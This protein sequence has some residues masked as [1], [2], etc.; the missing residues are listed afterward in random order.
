MFVQVEL[1]Y[2]ATVP[3][4]AA[5]LSDPAYGRSRV[6]AGGATAN[7]IEIIG[8]S[9]G[10]FTV[11]TRRSMPTDQIPANIRAFVGT[12]LEVRQ[13]EA[14]EAPQGDARRGTVVVEIAG[15]PVRLTGTTSLVHDGVHGA[16]LTYAGEVKAGVPLFGAAI[17]DAAARAV[18]SALEAEQQSGNDWLARHPEGETV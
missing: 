12:S 15:A 14:W 5:M 11:T 2:R 3:T 13:I 18:R 9:D 10:A 1:R 16:V 4:V 8:D 6:A 7:H 17:E